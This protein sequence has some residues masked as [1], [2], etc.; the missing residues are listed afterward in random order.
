MPCWK[1]LQLMAAATR[2]F[3]DFCAEGMEANPGRC[4]AAVEK[5][6]SMVTSLNP[7]IGY[8]KAAALAKEAFKTGRDHPR[9]VPRG[10]NPPGSHP[11]RRTRPLE[12][13]RTPRLIGRR[14]CGTVCRRISPPSCRATSAASRE[15]RAGRATHGN[16]RLALPHGLERWF[17]S[18]RCPPRPVPNRGTQRVSLDS[19]VAYGRRV[20]LA[21]R[22]RP[23]YDSCYVQLPARGAR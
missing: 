3:V 18:C 14:T 11:S 9:T 22:V 6:L 15:S 12:H 1:A 13:D 19:T 16:S 21:C 17:A 10:R 4:E 7:L 5:S 20:L 2:A 8:E 23:C